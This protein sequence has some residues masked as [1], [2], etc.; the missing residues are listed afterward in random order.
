MPAFDDR[1]ASA[2]GAF[3]QVELAVDRQGAF[4]VAEIARRANADLQA[5]ARGRRERGNFALTGLE[6]LVIPPTE[7]R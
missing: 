3:G 6:L 5:V 1:D 2:I 7:E 4:E